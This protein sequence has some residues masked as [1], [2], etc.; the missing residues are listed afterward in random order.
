M[1]FAFF[2]KYYCQE[3][4]K[5]GLNIHGTKKSF[6]IKETAKTSCSRGSYK[7]MYK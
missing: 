6:N 4:Q 3:K 5:N 1:L 2:R 7:L